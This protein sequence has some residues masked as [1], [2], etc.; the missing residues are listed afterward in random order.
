MHILLIVC[1][2]H[3]RSFTHAIAHQVKETLLSAGHSISV[4][5]LYQ[6]GFDPVLPYAEIVGES[7]NDLVNQHVNALTNADGLVIVHPNWWG[8][9]PAMLAG[10]IDRVLR[11]NA[12]YSFPKGEEGGAPDGLLKLEAAIIF[13]TSNTTAQREKH[14][15]GDP[16]E[17]IWKNCV[18]Q[19]CG[20][21]QI[22]RQTFSVVVDSSL[23][24]RKVWLQQ[25]QQT[26]LTHFP[27]SK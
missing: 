16:L 5:D 22:I 18:L 13:N 27:G 12:A 6:E 21:K 9:P 20:V 15:F 1:H 8:K 7:T 24:E 11:L 25:V 10:W 19:F 4:H 2:P 23:E 14:V 17:N 26:I 3:L